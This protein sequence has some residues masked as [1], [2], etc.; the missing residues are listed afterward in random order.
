MIKFLEFGKFGGSPYLESQSHSVNLASTLS[1]VGVNIYKGGAYRPTETL[2]PK[3]LYERTGEIIADIQRKSGLPSTGTVE[4]LGPKT[5][6]TQLKPDMYYVPG[7]FMFD[8]NLKE[9]LAKIGTPILLERHPDA[10]TELWL[11]AAGEIIAQGYHEV[12]LVETGKRDGDHLIVDIAEIAT[13]VETS[14][15]PILVHASRVAKT[16]LECRSIAKAVLAAGTAGV[17][18][19]VHPD[20]LQGLLTAGYCLSVEQ[21]KDAWDSFKSLTV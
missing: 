13:L 15:L 16:E 20:P 9:Q 14:P 1:L 5:A 6:I 19:D 7:E 4:A 18:L 11:Q 3:D 12:A 8:T 10:T 17:I 2:P 21:F